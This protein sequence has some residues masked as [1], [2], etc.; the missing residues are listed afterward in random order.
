VAKKQFAILLETNEYP[1]L[2][3]A[4][5]FSACGVTHNLIHTF[6]PDDMPELVQ[7][8]PEG[9]SPALYTGDLGA[10]SIGPQETHRSSKQREYISKA[11]WV[12]YWEL[13]EMGAI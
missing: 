9:T 2:T 1:M 7:P 10:G 6:D 13:Q 3:Q 12:S 4:K 11:M 8:E 5:I